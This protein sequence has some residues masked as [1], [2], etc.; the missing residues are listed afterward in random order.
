MRTHLL[1]R[2]TQR[3]HVWLGMDPLL[4]H[5]HA[6][7]AAEYP[8]GAERVAS[9][10]V[11]RGITAPSQGTR[12]LHAASGISMQVSSTTATASRSSRRSPLP[13]PPPASSAEIVPPTLPV[14]NWQKAL[15]L[16]FM[17]SH[18][19]LLVLTGAG[20]STESGIPD[21]RCEL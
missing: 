18:P 19:R 9:C 15:L 2:G 16:E 7:A 12:T 1:A 20:L 10:F 3:R 6:A 11:T 4:R 8:V 21:Y 13:P 5:E 14:A 17:E